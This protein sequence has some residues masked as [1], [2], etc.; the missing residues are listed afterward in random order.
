[1]NFELLPLD[2]TMTILR[3]E[4][5]PQIAFKKIVDLGKEK[6]PSPIWNEYNEIYID[7]DIKEASR[8]IEKSIQYHPNSKGFYFGLDTLNMDNGKGTN[9]EIGLSKGC[10]PN[11][12][13]DDWTYDCESFG[14]S[15]LIRGLFEFSDTFLNK[16]KWSCDER[17]FTEYLIFLGYSGV[18]LR[19]ALN[20]LKT[21]NNFLSTWGFHDGDMF[22]L[23]QKIGEVRAI[24]TEIDL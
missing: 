2:E 17:R 7:R 8:W 1:M 12:F 18:I 14:K 6:F 9:I 13:S 15:H 10:N 21:E 4:L 5:N 22:F 16:D 11:E 19:E 24:V 20:N 23:M 3:K